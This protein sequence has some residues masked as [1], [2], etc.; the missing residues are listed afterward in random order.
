[1]EH[2]PAW[3]TRLKCRISGTMP[4]SPVS[5]W[6]RVGGEARGASREGCLPAARSPQDCRSSVRLGP[7]ARR[8]G[9]GTSFQNGATWSGGRA[10]TSRAPPGAA[11]IHRRR[12]GRHSA[13]GLAVIAGTLGGVGITVLTKRAQA[14]RVTAVF[15]RLSNRL[16][17]AAVCVGIALG[18]VVL[19]LVVG[20]GG[21]HARVTTS[22]SPRYLFDD[23]FSGQAGSRPSSLLWDAKA[24]RTDSGT[25][26]NGWK[27]ISED[28]HGHLVIT[29]KKVNGAWYSGFLSGKTSYTGPRYIAVRAKVAAGNGVWNAP[30]W[31]WDLP[32]GARGI[33]DDVVEQL[34]REPQSYRTT[35]HA[36]TAIQK[37]FVSVTGVN[38]SGGFHTYSA[39]VRPG[40]VD[41]YFDGT[42]QRTIRPGELGGRWGFVTTP[43][44]PNISLAMGGLGG[45]PTIAGP[46]SLLVDWVRVAARHG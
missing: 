34:G 38:L 44:V 43:M 41:F 7:T 18:I 3:S 11:R 30:V 4:R 24:Y 10:V 26:W 19:G 39:A 33:E 2:G 37:G 29:A 14:E 23:E 15:S 16:G 46:L 35:L 9:R 20:R 25:I 28:G 27:N 22:G 36:G 17:L 21:H 1:M 40:R 32:D 31:E 6:A 5:I 12:A 42:L 13:S 8:R 45:T